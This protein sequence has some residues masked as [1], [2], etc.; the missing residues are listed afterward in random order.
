MNIEKIRS[1]FKILRDS[2]VVY[3]DN[4]ATSL[5]PDSVLLSMN[6]FYEEINANPGR[7]VHTLASTARILYDDAHRSVASFIGA[8]KDGEVIFTKNATEAINLVA[9][10]IRWR[11]GDRIITTAIE[12]HSNFLPWLRLKQRYGVK[13]DII[14]PDTSGQFNLSE[15]KEIINDKTRLLAF[16]HASNV[17]GSITPAKKL[18]SIARDRKVLTL[19]DG[20]QFVPHRAV[21][22]KELGCDF[23]A[24]SA[25]KMLGPMG[26]GALYVSPN[27]K[28]NLSPLI[29][30]G[31]EVKDAGLDFFEL[32]PSWEGF[33]GGT[34]NVPGGLGFA[35]A[36]EY[37]E[38]TGFDEIVKHEEKL[39][40]L[41][42]Q[43]LC[44]FDK[45]ETYGPGLG[46]DRTGIVSFNIHGVNPH[47]VSSLYN[48]WGNI[49]IRSGHMCAY[50]L[51]KNIIK[52]PRGV[53]RAST[54]LYNTED[55]VN[56]F[57]EVTE[58]IMKFTLK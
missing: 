33:E 51:M 27:E 30:G 21:D 42:I 11:D 13:I 4:A 55:E 2:D 16:S 10:G 45:I 31:G 44:R 56:R 12:H 58:K 53:V 3:L 22:V 57:L 40:K 1:D 8:D 39:T 43:G 9:S 26:M 48:E 38:K 18:V 14:C 24:F 41:L 46:E 28:D 19:I 47:R 32:L 35:S 25:H 36:I 7:S 34:Q 23:Y 20:A 49:L 52:R 29:L 15:F 50:P 6:R 17:L 54:Y 5:T 37:I